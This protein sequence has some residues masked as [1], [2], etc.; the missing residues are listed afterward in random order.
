MV[1][2][3]TPAERCGL[4]QGDR[5]V[6]VND[7]FVVFLPVTEVVRALNMDGTLVAWL[8]VERY[9]TSTLVIHVDD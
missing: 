5:L 4:R 1:R 6:T 7:V 9:P 8:E 2:A 3:N